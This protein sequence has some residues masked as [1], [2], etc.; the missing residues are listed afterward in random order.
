MKTSLLGVTSLIACFVVSVATVAA[1]VAA[2]AGA[3]VSAP[4][5]APVMALGLLLIGVGA[6]TRRH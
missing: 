3:L 1:S 5:P 4:N 2:P 6:L